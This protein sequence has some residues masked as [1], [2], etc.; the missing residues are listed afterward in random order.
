[1]HCFV[2]F[3]QFGEIKCKVGK[4]CALG[5]LHLHTLPLDAVH[6]QD[7]RSVSIHR[8]ETQV[9]GSEGGQQLWSEILSLLCTPPE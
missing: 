2:F 7:I 3:N 5:G 8:I 1:M 9:V 4:Q 6:T